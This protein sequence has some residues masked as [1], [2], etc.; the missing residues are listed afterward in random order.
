MTDK[1]TIGKIAKMAGV[2]IQTLRFYER[3]NLLLPS[4]RKKSNFTFSHAGYRTY[5]EDAVKKILFI[6]NAQ[7]LGFSLKEVAELLRLRVGPRLKSATLRKRAKEKLAEVEEKLKKLDALQ[8]TLRDLIHI[9]R[10]K[11]TTD[12]CP[13]LKS[14]ELL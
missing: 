11:G 13:I 12:H 5:D 2:N 9:C 8:R 6:K 3:K 10:K 7:K 14:L 4:G 1:L